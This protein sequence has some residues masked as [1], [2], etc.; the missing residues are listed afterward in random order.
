MLEVKHLQNGT[1]IPKTHTIR[2][3]PSSI[4]KNSL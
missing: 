1:P 2:S 4:P 3:I